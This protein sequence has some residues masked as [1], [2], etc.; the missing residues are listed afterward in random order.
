MIRKIVTEEIE[1]QEKGGEIIKPQLENT[2]HQ[3]DRTLHE[4]VDITKSL[5]FMQ[6]QL[7]EELAKLKNGVGKIQTDK[8]YRAP[9]FRPKLCDEK[10]TITR[11]W[12]ASK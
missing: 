11:K 6:E 4:V 12:I 3:L 2:S 10:A 1:N 8:G 5:E 7:D 9:S